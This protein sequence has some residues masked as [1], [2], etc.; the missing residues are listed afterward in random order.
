MSSE[1]AK[2]SDVASGI[3]P[4]ALRPIQE[5]LRLLVLVDAEVHDERVDEVLR[6]HPLVEQRRA[7]VVAG[8]TVMLVERR[9][10][11]D[12]PDRLHRIDRPRVVEEILV[13]VA[14]HITRLDP[15]QREQLDPAGGKI[16]DI[17][18]GTDRAVPARHQAAGTRPAEVARYRLA[19]ELTARGQPSGS[20]A[21]E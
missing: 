20:T 9:V 10:R 16:A 7:P 8:P 13:D 1:P 17:K 15:V 5:Q 2:V 4:C 6:L 11:A 21:S 3:G 19:I 12:T 14:L 18:A